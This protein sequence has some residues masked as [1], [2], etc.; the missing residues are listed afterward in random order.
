[1]RAKVRAMVARMGGD[2]A[3]RH[4]RVAARRHLREEWVCD[5]GMLALGILAGFGGVCIITSAVLWIY[6]RGAG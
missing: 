4:T 3:S 1:M 6:M 5:H 2:V